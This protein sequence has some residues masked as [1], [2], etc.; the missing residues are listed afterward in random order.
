MPERYPPS[1]EKLPHSM[2]GFLPNPRTTGRYPPR[3]LAASS[4]AA[5]TSGCRTSI[6]ERPSRA[7]RTVAWLRD[8]DLVETV[9]TRGSYVLPQ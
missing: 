5:A 4:T 2:A 1:G 6:V 8:H 7:R 9:P 3:G